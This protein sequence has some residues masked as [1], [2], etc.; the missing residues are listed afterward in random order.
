MSAVH[1]AVSLCP[2]GVKGVQHNSGNECRD[3]DELLEIGP[4]ANVRV[5]PMWNLASS[6]CQAPKRRFHQFLQTEN[7][8]LGIYITT[9]NDNIRPHGSS[10]SE[11]S[12]IPFWETPP[13]I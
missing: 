7:E 6:A 2:L 4:I 3:I 9:K 5:L 12:S 1:R 10:H 11:S 13:A 8:F